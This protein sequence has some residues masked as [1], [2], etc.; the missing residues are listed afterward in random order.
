MATLY[1]ILVI[2]LGIIIYPYCGTDV[3]DGT[4][5]ESLSIASQLAFASSDQRYKKK[6]KKSF[7]RL[8]IKIWPLNLLLQ[9]RFIFTKEQIHSS[10]KI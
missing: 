7:Y 6:K 5:I 3:F 8:K 10:L 1:F 2:N 4:G 9:L